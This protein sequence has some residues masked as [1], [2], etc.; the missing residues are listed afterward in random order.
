M[1][2]ILITVALSTTLLAQDPKPTRRIIVNETVQA[3]A[4]SAVAPGT[5][6]ERQSFFYVN[7][8]QSMELISGMGVGPTV[9]KSPYSAEVVSESIQTL[10]DGNRIVQKTAAKQFRDSDG[11]ERREEGSP[12]NAVFITDPVAKVS[13]TLRPDSKTA[14][15]MAFGGPNVTSIRGVIGA[16]RLNITTAP[17][18]NVTIAAPGNAAFALAT[19]VAT[20][21]TNAKEKD[22]GTRT[23]EG[24]QA[25][26]TRSTVT[27]PAGEIGNDRAI[28]ITDERW[29]SPDLQLTIL[30]RHADPRMGETTFKLTSIQRLEQVR[31]LFE[32][33]PGYTIHEAAVFTRPLKEE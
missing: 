21:S 13:Y 4:I 19:R 22:L 24:V 17:P 32:V 3:G 30:T 15:K 10:Y 1:K 6:V 27:I 12:M 26:G 29:Y 14:E 23:I 2:I 5:T 25:K 9:T 20:T 28:D 16:E 11:R 31:S 18:P 33:P 7:G 8:P